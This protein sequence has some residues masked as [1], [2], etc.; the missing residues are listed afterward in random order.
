M[1]R[2][3]TT[4]KGRRA[5]HRARRILEAAGYAV[6]RSAASKGPADLV[7]WNATSIR[8]VQVKSGGGYLS[9]VERETFAALRVPTNA[10]REVWRFPGRQA[11]LIETL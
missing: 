8:F 3:N 4:M 5:E 1:G 7:A 10:S 11:P 2:I 6:V 9:A